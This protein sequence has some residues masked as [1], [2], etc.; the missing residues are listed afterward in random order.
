MSDNQIDVIIPIYNEAENI[1][2]LIEK[3]KKINFQILINEF[4]YKLNI[5]FVDDGSTD[6]TYDILE[7]LKKENLINFISYQSN[8]GKSFAMKA[9]LRISKSKYVCFM[10]G[11]LQD[12]PLQ[13]NVLLSKLITS[14]SDLVIGWRY[15]RKDSRFKVFI[16][17]L[18]NAFIS[19]LF[20]LKFN[21]INSGFKILKS[22]IIKDI[23]LYGNNHRLFPLFLRLRGY[24]VTE[25]KIKSYNRLHGK[26]KYS[27][28]R[29]DGIVSLLSFYI[30]IKSRENPMIFFGKIS[31]VL[32]IFSMSLFLYFGISQIFF[33]LGITESN[34][35]LRPLMVV[36]LIGI[37]LSFIIFSVG[38]ICEYILYL[39]NKNNT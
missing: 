23:V 37:T 10:D 4:K 24:K 1:I 9:G 29:L 27:V 17:K 16:S 18:F 25:E 39:N 26:S 22:E 38:F 36:S 11:D 32:F 2:N 35:L 31:L 3:F 34:V 8:L 7:N 30:L 14:N 13:I 15:Y 33:L 5:I 19:K 6:N 28:L 21:D 12:D 20:N